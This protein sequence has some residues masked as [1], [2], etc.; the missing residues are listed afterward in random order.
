M[1]QRFILTFLLAFVV[2]PV[3][4]ADLDVSIEPNPLVAGGTGRIKLKSPDSMPE[5]KDL[6]EVEGI[7]WK[8]GVSTAEHIEIVNFETKRVYTAIYSFEVLKDGEIEF[9]ALRVKVGKVKRLVNPFKVESGKGKAAVADMIFLEAAFLTDKRRFYAGEEI[10]LE[11]RFYSVPGIKVEPSWPDVSIKNVAFRKFNRI[12]PKASRFMPYEQKT[13][14]DKKKTWNVFIFKTAFRPLSTGKIENAEVSIATD[15]LIPRRN[16]RRPGNSFF[17]EDALKDF[18][19]DFFF[20]DPFGRYETVNRVFR[21]ELPDIEVVPL[22]PE[23]DDSEFL[24]L[25][26]NWNVS[27]GLDDEGGGFRAGDP[28]SLVLDINGYGNL[29]NL[30]VPD[31]SLRGFRVFPPTTEKKTAIPG[32]QEQAKIRYV[33]IP[34]EEGEREISTSFS[35]FAPSEAKYRKFQ[36]EKKISIA[37]SLNGTASAVAVKA[38]S[39]NEPDKSADRKSDDILDLKKYASGSVTLP[40]YAHGMWLALLVALSGPVVLVV[41]TSILRRRREIE[42]NP[43]QRRRREALKRKR[44][45]IRAVRESENLQETVSSKVAPYLNDLSSAPPGTSLPELVARLEDPELADSLSEF[46]DSSY[47]PSSGRPGGAPESREKLIKALKRFQTVILIPVLFL[48]GLSVSAS[49]TL[50]PDAMD[51]YYNEDFDR[52]LKIYRSELDP[53]RPDPAILYNIG[54]CHYRNGDPGMALLNYERARRIAPGDSDILENCNFVRRQLLLSEHG[55]IDSPAQLVSW[56]RDRLRPDEWLLISAFAFSAV[57]I[58]IAFAEKMKRLCV[59]AIPVALLLFAAGITACITQSRSSYAANSALVVSKHSDIYILP[60]SSSEKKD[61]RY[62]CGE[63]LSILDRRSKWVR[64][65]NPKGIEG[66]IK[67]DN[68]ELIFR[69]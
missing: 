61:S 22:P 30:V 65:K 59:A 21:T 26:G 28:L 57:F 18:D 11:I 68:V 7:R 35:I 27:A 31:I 43:E 50:S 41:Y 15:I 5:I 49:G 36:L 29:E 23:P 56:C 48:S 8:Q 63:T 16:S 46:S 6:P 69:D 53:A 64:T 9:P 17:F 4:A 44:E 12:N 54:N 14:T 10:Q 67:A 45:L 37:R 32:K 38:R 13:V 62:H 47:L 39:R 19:D 55:R 60:S 40:V 2:F 52:A 58:S 25:I 34:E 33:L 3:L 1:L 20:G 66:W 51:A 24:G 42:N